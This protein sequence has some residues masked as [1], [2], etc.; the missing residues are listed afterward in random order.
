MYG[1]DFDGGKDGDDDDSDDN[2]G[3]EVTAKRFKIKRLSGWAKPREILEEGSLYRLIMTYFLQELCQVSQLG[4]NLLVVEIGTAGFPHGPI[5]NKL[6][7]MYNDSMHE[8]LNLFTVNHDVYVTGDMEKGAP[9]KFN[10][11]YALAFSQGMEII[12]KHYCRA[13]TWQ[14]QSDS[15][16]WFDAYCGTHPYLLLYH[17]SLQECG[18]Q[19]LSSLAVPNKLPDSVVKISSF[20]EWVHQLGC[21]R[22]RQKMQ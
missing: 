16:K 8:S 4:T 20:Q 19:V 9:A 1:K 7:S 12:D 6:V 18:N 11:L 10:V 3:E 17:H 15:H 2:I 13:Q 5:Y 21:Q 14:V 22:K